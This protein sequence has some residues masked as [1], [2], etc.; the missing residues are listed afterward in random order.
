MQSDSSE[1]WLLLRFSL[2][3]LD[4]VYRHSGTLVRSLHDRSTSAKWET[5]A[6]IGPEDLFHR[7][8][9]RYLK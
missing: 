4:R 1:T 6:V 8:G 2:F 9:L 3:R 7:P 5:V